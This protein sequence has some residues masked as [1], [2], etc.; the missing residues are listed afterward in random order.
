MSTVAKK[1]PAA[2]KAAKKS[3]A[4][5]PGDMKQAILDHLK[6]TLAHNPSAAT[7]RDWWTCISLAVRDRIVDNMIQTQQTHFQKNV[8][9]CYYLSMEYLM[10]RMLVNNMYSAG[11]YDEARAA[12]EELGVDW[13]AIVEEELDMGL[14]NGGLGRLAACFLDSLATLD[15]PA[16]GYGIYYEF[17]LFKQAFQNGHQ[18]EKPDSWKMFGTPWDIV[19]PEYTQTLK[20]YG[21]VETQFDE[22]GDPRPVW[23]DTKTI[24]GVPYD[25]PI[26]GYDTKTVNFLRLWSSRSSEEFDLDE[27]NKG[28]YVE[29]IREKAIG[30][31]ISKVLYPNDKTEN[32]KELRLVQQYFFVSCSLHDIIRRYF[33]NNE[34]WDGF[35]DKVAIQLNDTHPAIGVAELMRILVDEHQLS[36]DKAWEISTKTF[37]YTNHT[38]LPEALE[39]WSVPLFE[40]VLPRH[41]EIIFEI[42]RRLME[43]IE[44]R[45]PGD[46]WM[47]RDLSLIEEGHPK[48]V[49]MAHLAVVGSHTVNGVAAIHSELLK[50]VLFP[51]F[52]A[53]YPNK[54]TNMTNGITP[55]RWL[56]ACNPKL[57]KLIDSKKIPSDWPKNLDA[58]RGLEKYADDADFQDSYMKIKYENKVELA[59]TIK[60]LCHVEVD[61]NA[62]FDVQIKRLHEYKRQHLNLLHILTLYRRLL[63]NPDLDIAPRVFVFGAKAAPGYELA[64]RIIK[65]INSVGKVINADERIKGK[66]KVVFLPNYR[67]SLAAKII[68]AADLSEQIS[69]AGKEASGTGNMKLALNG[70]LTIGTLDGA[71]IEIGEE[72]GDD[73][74]FIFGLNV[75]E[76]QALDVKGYDPFSYYHADEELKAVVDWIGSSYFTPDEPDVLKPVRDS[77][78]DGGDPFKALADYRAYIECQDRV[79]EAFKDKKLWARMAILNTARVGKFSTDRTIGQYASEIW[80]LPPVEVK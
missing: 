34:S 24:Q 23:V 39:K 65:A 48:M 78:L 6:Y 38:L 3:A 63:H 79:G 45:W 12:V 67:V 28:D 16:I 17:G 61:P 10:G 53:L 25:I 66:L 42:N 21:R 80:N 73:N 52:N 74:I 15:L 50:T 55:R 18:I 30:E 20:V 11:V 14:G 57:S 60:E 26:A 33:K 69:T 46:N 59:K 62:L 56:L 31:T 41:L 71:N 37:A 76:V 5:A 1:K 43:T 54:F 40:K 58:L 2:K 19:R 68:P 49:R 7:K 77:M 22:K 4:S 29:A 47:K 8:R 72:V 13:N 51:S 36:W 75:D 27:F 44:D 64:K 70:A 35:A 9:R 32:G